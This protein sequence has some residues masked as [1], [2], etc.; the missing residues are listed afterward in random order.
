MINNYCHISMF[1][2]AILILVFSLLPAIGM[3]VQLT[4]DSVLRELYEAQRYNDSISAIHKDLQL[5]EYK[6]KM[7]SLEQEEETEREELI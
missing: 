5:S 4:N 7:E 6:A 3:H 2:T 1:K